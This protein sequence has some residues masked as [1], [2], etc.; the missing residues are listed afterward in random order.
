M[1]ATAHDT[2]VFERS[3]ACPPGMLYDA[4][5]DPVARARW[6]APSPTAVII[7]DE[8]DF[9]VGGRDKSRCGSK[10]DPRFHVEVRYLHIVPM[11]RIVYS[12]TVSESGT[13]LSAALQTIE[14]S[15]TRGGSALK[16]TV[17]IASFG[18]AGMA[19]GVRFGFNAALDNLARELEG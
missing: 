6:G 4:F 3:F 10:A 18:D 19:D 14:I 9:R 17:Q 5:A 12:E 13:T 8:T 11:E 1:T 16:V 7:Y 2:I 15:N